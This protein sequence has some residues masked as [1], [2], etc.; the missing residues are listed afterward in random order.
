V[1]FPLFSLEFSPRKKKEEFSSSSSSE[2]ERETQKDRQTQQTEERDKK[3]V[4]GEGRP[5]RACADGIDYAGTD[6]V[7]G[8]TVRVSFFFFCCWNEISKFFS[9]PL[10]LRLSRAGSLSLSSSFSSSSS[11]P[12]GVVS[13]LF[14]ARRSFI[15]N[16][17]F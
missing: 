4:A 1:F 8:W 10:S 11:S 17:G 5:K 15:A 6:Q 13:L 12:L 2:R 3:M 14:A 7:P 9:R 16:R